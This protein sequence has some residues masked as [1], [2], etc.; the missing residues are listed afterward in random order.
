MFQDLQKP[1]S[2]C[3]NWIDRVL[4]LVMMQFLISLLQGSKVQNR[5]WLMQGKMNEINASA[6]L[7]LN[8]KKSQNAM[9]GARFQQ[10]WFFTICHNFFFNRCSIVHKLMIGM[11]NLQVESRV[12]GKSWRKAFE[13]LREFWMNLDLDLKLWLWIPIFCYD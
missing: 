12:E 11:E 4:T 1:Y 10:W 7:C 3:K 13:D 2:N 5:C 9:K 6:Q 8:S